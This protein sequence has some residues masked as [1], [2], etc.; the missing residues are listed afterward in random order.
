MHLP[1]R[2]QPP[3]SRPVL[4]SLWGYLAPVD[5]SKVGGES[6][7]QLWTG[8]NLAFVAWDKY[9]EALNLPRNKCEDII[10]A[11]T[12]NVLD[13]GTKTRIGDHFVKWSKFI[14][15]VLRWFWRLSWV[16]AIIAAL[17]GVYVLYV[18]H[19][20]PWDW[21]L[22]LPTAVYVGVTIFVLCIFWIIT[23][24]VGW[25]VGPGEGLAG[26][27]DKLDRSTRK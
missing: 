15:F 8:L 9:K 18:N 22:I 23:N 12:C 1:D 26:E 5:W 17:C 16:S 2:K 6:F 25:C 24:F 11:A 7:V 19:C 14:I 13:S 27:I 21:I 10:N 4:F 3:P 20:G